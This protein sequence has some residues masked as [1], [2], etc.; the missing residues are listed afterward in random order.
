MKPEDERRAFETA[1]AADRYDELTHRA[2]ADW[3]DEQDQPELADFHRRWTREWQQAEDWLKAFAEE[4]AE[5]ADPAVT[6]QKV[7]EAGRV[8]LEGG[9]PIQIGGDD[10]FGACNQ[11]CS[12]EEVRAFWD[13]W[14]T[15]T[16]QDVPARKR[17]NGNVFTCCGGF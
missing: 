7:I 9:D 8:A 15:Y 6:F 10:G 4:A 14:A 5:G 12:A 17:S 3:L 1:L 16:R 11:M 2:F 13:A